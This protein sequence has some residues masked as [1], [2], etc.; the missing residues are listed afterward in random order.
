VTATLWL[1]SAATFLRVLP[2]LVGPLLGDA[3]SSRLLST[4]LSVGFGFSGP[5][6]LAALLCFTIN[7]WHI[8]HGTPRARTGAAQG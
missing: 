7:L 2:G 6:A 5:L 4:L 3:G 8:L 1:G